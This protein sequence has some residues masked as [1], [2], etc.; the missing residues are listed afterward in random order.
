[1]YILFA[2]R[3]SEAA[4]GR[5]GRG[6]GVSGEIIFHSLGRKVSIVYRVPE[7]LCCRMICILPPSPTKVSVG[8]PYIQGKERQR[9]GGLAI[10]HG[11]GKGGTQIIR[12][13]R[14]CGTLC[15]ILYR[16]TLAPRWSS[17]RK[18]FFCSIHM[19]METGEVFAVYRECDED[20]SSKAAMGEGGRRAAL[21]FAS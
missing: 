4:M 19:M 8:E 7:F 1:M 14:D 18:T 11:K 6:G 21:R 3:I 9:G 5:G 20:R 2:V 15:N 13:H 17:G 16:Y 10:F 12:Q